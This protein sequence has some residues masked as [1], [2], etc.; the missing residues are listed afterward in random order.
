MRSLLVLAALALASG[1]LPPRADAATPAVATAGH[2]LDFWLGRWDV[3]AAGKLDGTDV[4]E[5]TL[6]G[7]AVHERWSDADGSAGESFFYYAPA[8][9]RWTQVWMT[10]RGAYKVKQSEPVP[11]GVRFSGTA[12]RPDGRHVFDRTTLTQEPDH[13]VRQRIEVRRD[14][15]APWSLVYDATYRRA[16][17]R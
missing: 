8:E 17:S 10:D 3:Y 16:K 13:T 7:F 12:F 4:V 9:K 5:A 1:A 14:A 6:A 2:E 11:G 15:H